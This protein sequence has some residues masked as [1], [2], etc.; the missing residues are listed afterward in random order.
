MASVEPKK[1]KKAHK[2]KEDAEQA[3]TGDSKAA[4]AEALVPRAIMLQVD[5]Q[6]G[7]HSFLLMLHKVHSLRIVLTCTAGCRSSPSN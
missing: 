5:L 7:C 3:A 4:A 2:A 1:R 6:P